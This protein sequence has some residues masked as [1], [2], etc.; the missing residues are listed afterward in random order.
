M[1]NLAKPAPKFSAT[2]YPLFSYLMTLSDHYN[3]IAEAAAGTAPDHQQLRLRRLH[4]VK[5]LLAIHGATYDP[6]AVKYV[7][8][9]VDH[10]VSVW[11]NLSV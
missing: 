6:L 3:T 1:T 11:M 9:L 5:E 2:G 8:D 7:N 4:Y 10:L